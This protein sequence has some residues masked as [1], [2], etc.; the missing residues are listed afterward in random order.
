LPQ[1]TVCREIFYVNPLAWLNFT[2]HHRYYHHG[3]RHGYID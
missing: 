3:R 2:G 1:V